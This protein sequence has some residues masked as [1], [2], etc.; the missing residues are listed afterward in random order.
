[1]SLLE[2]KEEKNVKT[3]DWTHF[4]AIRKLLPNTEEKKV[5]SNW[6]PH[7]G[8]K[9]L[10]TQSWLFF[11]LLLF[12]FNCRSST[13]KWPFLPSVTIT[14]LTAVKFWAV[15]LILFMF[16]SHWNKIPKT[17]EEIHDMCDSCVGLFCVIQL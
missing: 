7:R 15:C 3:L 14:Q 5:I 12:L 13:G 6:K 11:K 9:L 16:E 4:H 17:I 10:V 1:M 2:V 8:K